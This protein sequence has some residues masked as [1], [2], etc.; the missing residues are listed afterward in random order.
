MT[1]FRR[2]RSPAKKDKGMRGPNPCRQKMRVTQGGP[3]CTMTSAGVEQLATKFQTLLIRKCPYLLFNPFRHPSHLSANYFGHARPRLRRWTLLIINHCR[4]LLL[5]QSCSLF[6]PSTECCYSHTLPTMQADHGQTPAAV[7]ALTRM[8]KTGP[9]SR[10]GR[11]QPTQI[12]YPFWFGGSASSMAACVTH[13]L[14]LGTP[15]RRT[16]SRAYKWINAN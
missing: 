6:S 8:E 1:R 11:K 4:F 12:H 13:P 16:F 5:F 9:T 10:G 7:G 15:A 14:D 3:R 2:P